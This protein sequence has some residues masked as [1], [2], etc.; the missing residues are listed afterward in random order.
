MG[1]K[2]SGP[3]AMK[4]AACRLI[5]AKHPARV[6]SEMREPHLLIRRM[7]HRL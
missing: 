3:G 7:W 6:I 1:R 5:V 4:A 2:I